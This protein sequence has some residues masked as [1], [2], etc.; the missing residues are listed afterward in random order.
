MKISYGASRVVASVLAFSLVLLPA[1]PVFA[2]GEITAPDLCPNIAGVQATIPSGMVLDGSGN[3]ITPTAPVIS[4]A[5]A[6]S[7]SSVSQSLVWTVDKLST[8]T[9]EYGT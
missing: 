7:I 9:F 5:A 2:L 6:A 4:G 3:C 8:F 1:A